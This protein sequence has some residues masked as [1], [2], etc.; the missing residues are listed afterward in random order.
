MPY[1]LDQ[2]P[3]VTLSPAYGR[4]YETE[5]EVLNDWYAGKD[6]KIETN[7]PY[8]SIRD[9]KELKRDKKNSKREVI[10]KG[11][12]MVVIMWKENT[13]VEVTNRGEPLL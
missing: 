12:R 13:Y 3:M 11:N 2:F 5:V 8:T 7:G 10:Q 6:F 1:I 4:V 9:L